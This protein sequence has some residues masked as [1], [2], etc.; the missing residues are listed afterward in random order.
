MIIIWSY[1]S[2]FSKTPEG[3]LKTGGAF[4]ENR[5]TEEGTD[6]WALHNG[7][8]SITF[9]DLPLIPINNKKVANYFSN[10]RLS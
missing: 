3:Y 2:L 4:T 1:G 8:I 5:V 10:L 7:F 6:M 9:F